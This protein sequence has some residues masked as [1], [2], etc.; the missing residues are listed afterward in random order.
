MNLN[1]RGA[2]VLSALKQAGYKANEYSGAA[3]V[4]GDKEILGRYI[5]GQVVDNL[6][7]GMPPHPVASTFAAQY[8][9]MPDTKPAITKAATFKP[10]GQS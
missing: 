7:S 6:S 9:A 1:H 5:L 10:P 2:E 4:K 3:F 8:L